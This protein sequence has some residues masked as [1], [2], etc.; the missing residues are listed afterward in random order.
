MIASTVMVS[1][2]IPRKVIQ[3]DG[4]SILEDF[5]GALICLHSANMEL[6]LW[7]QMGESDNPAVR[8]LS[9]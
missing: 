1:K 4:P 9:R 5:M 8:K 3:M 7:L 2:C 6:R